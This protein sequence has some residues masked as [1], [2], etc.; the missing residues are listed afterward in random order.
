MLDDK[1]YDLKQ[2]SKCN[3]E[4]EQQNRALMDVVEEI[5]TL[6]HQ[7]LNLNEQT[8]EGNLCEHC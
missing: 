1:W 6:V 5:Q 7:L 2:V 3:R 4:A 8:V